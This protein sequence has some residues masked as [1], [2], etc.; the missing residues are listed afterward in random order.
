MRIDSHVHFWRFIPED[1]PWMSAEMDVL[2]RDRLPANARK[3]LDDNQ[4][5]ACIAVQARMHEGETDFLL[6]LARNY[7]WIAGVIGWVDLIDDQ[8]P[9]RL[10]RW[11]SSKLLK[12]FRHILQDNPAAASLVGGDAF[13]RGVRLLQD[14]SLLYELLISADQLPFMTDFAR[15]LDGYWLV[16]DHL[17]KPDIRNRQFGTWLR[18]VT[19]LARLPHVVCKLSGIV[20]EANDA[21]GEFDESQ[22]RPYLDTALGLFGAERLMFGSDWPV[23]SLVASYAET[24]GLLE[25]WS[26]TLSAKERAWIFGKTATRIYGLEEPAQK[27]GGSP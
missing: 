13:R 9:D 16:L 24:A 11:L 22:I 12:G 25:R 15:T 5:D 19:P 2:K 26:T 21:R 20:T 6:G 10:E 23:C 4:I 8:L 1:Y 18:D 3:L 27:A 14:R 7:P 17:G